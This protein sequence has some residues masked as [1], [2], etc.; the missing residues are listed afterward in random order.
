[1]LAGNNSN[2]SYNNVGLISGLWRS[3]SAITQIDFTT[4]INFV[5]YSKIALYGIKGFRSKGETGVWLDPDKKGRERKKHTIILLMT[6]AVS[7]CTNIYIY[8]F[9]K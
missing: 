8:I 2:S 9:T 1:M 3:T 6:T 7:V 5:Q 4:L